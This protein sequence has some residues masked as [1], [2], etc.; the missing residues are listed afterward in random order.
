MSNPNTIQSDEDTLF[1]EEC[2]QDRPYT[3]GCQISDTDICEECLKNLRAFS[4]TCDHA[5]ELYD[6]D[7][8]DGM[9]CPKCC[10]VQPQA[11]GAPS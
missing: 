6:G 11:E 8:G 10:L 3:E 2:G 7:L 9:W 5:W 4:A 1:C